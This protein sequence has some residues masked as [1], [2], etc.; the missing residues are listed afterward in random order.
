MTE[1]ALLLEV[2]VLLRLLEKGE[3][4]SSKRSSALLIRLRQ[5]RWIEPS[6]RQSIWL[7]CAGQQSAVGRRLDALR[8]S[9]RE[10]AQLLRGANLDPL[11]PA[12]WASVEGLRASP[13]TAGMVH[14]KTWNAA[15][16]AGSKAASRLRSDAIQTDDWCLRGRVNCATLLVTGEKN[17]DLGEL[18]RALTEFAIPERGWRQA[19]GFGGQLPQLVLT[20]ENIGALVDLAIPPKTMVLY[21]QGKAYQGAIAVLQ[22]LEDVPW[23]HFG[24]LD[25]AGFLLAER[26]A[27]LVERP[28][29]FYVPTFAAEYLLRKRPAKKKWR[30]DGWTQPTV[31]QLALANSWLEQELF[32]LDPRLEAD[33]VTIAEQES[34]PT[35]NS[36]L[37]DN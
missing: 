11:N 13:A 2:C 4:S 14:R 6:T 35:D 34:R 22:A 24:D 21:S 32:L 28:L 27:R 31:M 12:H 15:T 7:L 1:A 19:R 30:V 26:M 36:T 23:V 8:P 9:W 5:A 25:P 3:C 37:L 16:S 20:V 29:H 10:D 18:T 17:V 33:L